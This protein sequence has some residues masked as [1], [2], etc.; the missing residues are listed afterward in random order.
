MSGYLN[1]VGV[2]DNIAWLKQVPSGSVDSCC[3]DAPYGLGEPPPILSVLMAWAR[4]KDFKPEGAGFMGNEWDAFVPNPSIWRE[5]FRILKPGGWCLVF[6]GSRT[7]DLGS[8]AIRVAGFEV[9][10]TCMWLYGQG[11]PKSVDIAKV[12]DKDAGHWR[13]RA[14]KAVSDNR[15]MAAPNYERT[16]KGKAITEDAKKW[17]GW[18]TALKPAFEPI[19]VARKPFEGT[20]VEHVLAHGTGALNIDASRVG[21]GADKGVWPATD[22]ET[23]KFWDKPSH[24]AVTDTSV[25]RWPANVVLAHDPRCVKVGTKT[26]GKGESRKG[27]DSRDDKTV[28]KPQ[29][30][31]GSRDTS[32]V[33]YGAEV[34]DDWRC[35][36]GCPIGLLDGQSGISK[37][38]GG[39]IGNKAGIGAHGI[40]GSF[41]PDAVKGDPGY[42][43]EG[44]ASRY[45]KTFPEPSRTV[46]NDD[47]STH[48]GAIC[49]ES[50]NT[51]EHRSTPNQAPSPEAS[52]GSTPESAGVSRGES[53][54]APMPGA[55]SRNATGAGTESGVSRE[56][57]SSIPNSNPGGS[58]S[59]TTVPSQTGTKSTTPTS[60]RRTTSTGTSSS[61]RKRNT[62]TSTDDS[63]KTTAS[64]TAAK[65][66]G[67]NAVSGGS[68]S[69]DS[70]RGLPEPTTATAKDAR[71]AI[72]VSGDGRTEST[73]TPTCGPTEN[74][75]LD[76]KTR[77]FYTA[78]ATAKERWSYC[79]ACKVVFQHTADDAFEEHDAHKTEVVSHPTQKPL[80]LMEYF[81]RLVTQPGGTVVDP[82][83]G[84]YDPLTSVL[85]ERGFVSWPDVR[86]D[87]VFASRAPDGSIIYQKAQGFVRTRYVG[88]MHHYVGRSVDL[89]VTPGH[90]MLFRRH[91]DADPTNY[92][93]IG[94]ENA[95]E[96]FY[97][98]PNTSTWTGAEPDTLRVGTLDLPAQAWLRFLGL[99]IAEGCVARKHK[100]G[101][102]IFIKQSKSAE[103]VDEVRATIRGIEVGRLREHTYDDLHIFVCQEKSLHA[104][105]KALG[106]QPDRR[107]PRELLS[108]GPKHLRALYDGL[109]LGDGSRRN[110]RDSYW[111]CSPG[112]ADDV[113]EM[114]IKLGLAASV[115]ARIRPARICMGRIIKSDR[116]QYSTLARYARETKIDTYRM[117]REVPYDGMI[118]CATVP[119][120]HT[121]LVKR[122][123]K[124]AWCGNTGST[125]VAAKRCGFNFVTCDIGEDYVKIA[126]A[127]LAAVTIGNDAK[128]GASYFCPGCKAKG[129]IKLIERATVER[130]KADG[131]KVTCSKCMKRYSYEELVGA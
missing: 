104:Y 81:V 43:D 56:A 59:N 78:K 89:L 96:R 118:Y 31:V 79:R 111:T 1:V 27:N 125:A 60:I 95:A 131:K 109:M 129:E 21:S 122:N 80:D 124:I 66:G 74:L 76:G 47:S 99:Y 110:G 2:S 84:C 48:D 103:A 126:E 33:D 116:Y 108:L 73:T 42:G 75:S 91:H 83:C 101:Y 35:V 112:L 37:S 63:A 30:P 128:I 92:E 13:G 44:G 17:E 97:H 62:T 102:G 115:S 55:T 34:V 20:Y 39:R 58:G 23:R 41:A 54:V 61:S 121:L 113:A 10:D 28:I 40:Y 11:F 85:T 82:F 26:V 105:C 87:D 86:D 127:R 8:I 123:G 94:S 117:R 9:L 57:G 52:G 65:S 19:V 98:I 46:D 32:I 18:G 3:T 12:V 51:A 93:L 14:G 119:P 106:Y 45:F 38:A 68:P 25:G 36:E 22:R 69:S 114:M 67:A 4:G 50:A 49:A 7:F 120:H 77:F 16:D 53:G 71:G 70:A 64:S 5:V 130:M 6:F 15:S 90:N 100:R 72:S 107:I 24:Q 88:V 29:V